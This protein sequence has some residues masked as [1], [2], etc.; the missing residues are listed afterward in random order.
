VTDEPIR[1]P[2]GFLPPLRGE[3]APVHPDLMDAEGTEEEVA[4]WRE[5]QLAAYLA[6]WRER[7]LEPV[8]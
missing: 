6:Y 7:G 4:V 1:H 3:G 5:R 8:E 2:F